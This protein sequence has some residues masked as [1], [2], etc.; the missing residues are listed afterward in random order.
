M[1]RKKGLHKLVETTLFS[2]FNKNGDRRRNEGGSSVDPT[3][4]LEIRNRIPNRLIHRGNFDPQNP[5]P[6]LRVVKNTTLHLCGVVVLNTRLNALDSQRNSCP[7]GGL[8][9]L[10]FRN[11]AG[12]ND[13]PLIGRLFPLESHKVSRGDVSDVDPVPGEVELLFGEDWVEEQVEPPLRRCVE[14]FRLVDFVQVWA[15]DL[16]SVR[17]NAAVFRSA[18]RSHRR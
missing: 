3:P 4:L 17:G 7:L 13:D 11:R 18:S 2:T 8:D 15:E 16:S 1:K 5:F 14:V 10:L 9:E 12:G 6:L